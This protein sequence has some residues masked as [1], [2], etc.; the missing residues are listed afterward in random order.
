M[1]NEDKTKCIPIPEP[2]STETETEA[3]AGCSDPFSTE[4][5]TGFEEPCT[6][7]IDCEGY[8]AS[9]CLLGQACSVEG[10]DITCCPA[11]YTCCGPCEASEDKMVCVPDE[12]VNLAADMGCDCES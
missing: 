3:E 5:P 1:P 11:N 10:C 8:E 4:G 6:S 2:P 7:H 12:Y 9:F